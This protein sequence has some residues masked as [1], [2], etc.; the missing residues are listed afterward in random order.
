[1][2]NNPITPTASSYVNG[3]IIDAQYMDDLAS[4][5]NREVGFAT[6]ATAASTK[7][8]VLADLSWQE[9]TGTTAAQVVVMPVTSTLGIG[10]KWVISNKST[11]TITVN[12]SGGN[13]IYTVPAATN[14]LFTCNAITGTTAASWSN[15][16]AG[17]NAVPA[18]GGKVLQVIQ[19]T[20]TTTITS[21][22]V[23]N[24]ITQ[25]ITPSSATSRILIIVNADVYITASINAVYSADI[26]D[27]T[28]SASLTTMYGGIT[29]LASGQAFIA[30]M[31][32]SFVHSPATTSS[33]NYALRLGTGSGGTTSVNN[34]SCLYSIILMEIGA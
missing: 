25:A 14:W 10:M 13:L 15:S 32:Q 11:Q 9:F 28:N 24:W 1:M 34:N 4:A 6:Q 31:S 2:A 8:L 12:S 23:A 16:Y 17:A 22:S 7:T 26:R 20:S 3:T 18:G 30:S 33:I 19:N 21:T 5:L 27:V 29:T